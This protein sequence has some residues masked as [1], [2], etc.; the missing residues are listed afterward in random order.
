MTAL[1]L[2]LEAARSRQALAVLLAVVGRVLARLHLL[3]PPAV[4][5]VP[6][7]GFCHSGVEVVARR[8]AQGAHLRRVEAVAGVVKGA[9]RD[10]AD[11]RARLG[12]DRKS[13]V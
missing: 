3:P 5:A 11:E 2:D 6:G 8:P 4:V 1:A 10:E 7:D 9:V 13:V 12:E